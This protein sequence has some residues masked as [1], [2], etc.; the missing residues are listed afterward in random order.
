MVKTH[1]LRQETKGGGEKV[2]QL[3]C[4]VGETQRFWR[5][6]FL[7]DWVESDPCCGAEDGPEREQP[8]S[9]RARAWAHQHLR[10]LPALLIHGFK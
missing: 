3:A 2:L 6:I 4:R 10:P 8:L 9:W 7:D 5:R 1:L